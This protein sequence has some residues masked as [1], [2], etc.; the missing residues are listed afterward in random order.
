MIGVLVRNGTSIIDKK[1]Y[2]GDDD[3]SL[4][5]IENDKENNPG[6]IFE[7]YLDTDDNWAKVFLK[8]TITITSTPDQNA[9][10]SAK[11]SGT[12]TA[13]SFLA[14]KIGLE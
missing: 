5:T 12:N 1:V 14:K 11:L 2:A 8:E 3:G 7:V 9:W 4:K 13:L 6:L 10:Q